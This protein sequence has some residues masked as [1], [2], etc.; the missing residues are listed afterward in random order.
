MLQLDE[1]QPIEQSASEVQ[2][3]AVSFQAV[4]FQLWQSATISRDRSAIPERTI[5]IP[6]P[7]EA[8]AEEPASR[9]RDKRLAPQTEASS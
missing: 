8:K 9:W 5:V 2:L 7:S 6:M 1:Q 3:S 4:S